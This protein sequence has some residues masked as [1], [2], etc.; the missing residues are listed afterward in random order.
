MGN[1]ISLTNR[2]LA[3]PKPAIKSKRSEDLQ[4]P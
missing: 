1:A 3:F 4:C 2:D